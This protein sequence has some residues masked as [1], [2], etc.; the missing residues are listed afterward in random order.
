[1]SRKRILIVD[2]SATIRAQVRLALDGSDFE[3]IDAA[4]GREGLDALERQSMSLVI[5]D[6]NMPR[7]NGIEMVTRMHE[8]GSTI[9]VVMLTTEG[10]PHLIKQARDKGARGWIVKPFNPELLAKAVQRLAV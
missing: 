7:M 8:G 1:M 9:P 5:C 10:H 6:V 2:D 4:D 3:V